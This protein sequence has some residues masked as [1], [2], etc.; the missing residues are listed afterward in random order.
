[1]NTRTANCYRSGFTL[2]ELLVVI[3]I[4]AGMLLPILSK[5]KS[6]AKG[7]HCVSNPKQWEIIRKLY[8]D[9][10]E[11]QFSDGDIGWAR[12]EWVVALAEHY[13]EKPA[14]LL[15]PDAINRWA[16]S[17]GSAEIKKPV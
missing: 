4:L 8:V 16:G 17:S 5:T 6:K 11:G 13:Q 1:M 9:D 7:I 2:I 12:G 15:C 3:A 14:L 10:N